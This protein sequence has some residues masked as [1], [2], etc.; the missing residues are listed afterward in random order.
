MKKL[1][2]IKI[3]IGFSLIIILLGT[4]FLIFPS[5]NV[6]D[7]SNLLYLILI[8]IGLLKFIEFMLSHDNKDYEQLFSSFACFI[9]CGFNSLVNFKNKLPLTLFVFVGLTCIIKLIKADYFNDRKNKLWYICIANLLIFLVIGLIASLNLYYNTEIQTL[10][11]G[12]VIVVYGFLD[13][14]VPFIKYLKIKKVK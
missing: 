14:V 3:N 9:T 13:L 1:T 6:T 8:V 4:F 2:K 12:F 5:I 10:F 7:A 11:I